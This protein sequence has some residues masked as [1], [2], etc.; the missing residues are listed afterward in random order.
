MSNKNVSQKMID[1]YNDLTVSLVMEQYS[2]ALSEQIQTEMDLANDSVEFPAEL[3]ERC[4][5]LIRREGRKQKRKAV[6]HSTNRVLKSVAMFAIVVFAMGSFLF[7]TVDAVRMPIMK[8]YME[9]M[10]GHVVIEKE[11]NKNQTLANMTIDYSDPLRGIIPVDYELIKVEGV[12]GQLLYAT[13]ENKYGNQILYKMDSAN[14]TVQFDMENA[15]DFDILSMDGFDAICV[16]KDNQ[17]RLFWMDNEKN[18]SFSLIAD[19]MAKE[20]LIQIAEALII[21]LK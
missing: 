6:L 13:Y 8:F 19:E 12:S 14:S 1:Q 18:K 3:D 10:D 15:T 11:K 4:R 9:Y 7:V 17:T 21:Y 20:D 5:E 16:V 2:S